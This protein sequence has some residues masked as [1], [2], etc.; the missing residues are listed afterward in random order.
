MDWLAEWPFRRVDG[1]GHSLSLSVTIPSAHSVDPT[2]W[3]FR[4]PFRRTRRKGHSVAPD[5]MAT[6]ACKD[7]GLAQEHESNQTENH[8]QPQL[9]LKANREIGSPA[10][11]QA[12][13]PTKPTPPNRS[14]GSLGGETSDNE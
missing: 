13:A 6:L 8:R 11:K 1:M 5:G 3:P 12:P 7:I 4:R 9:H 10:I 2:R 14:N